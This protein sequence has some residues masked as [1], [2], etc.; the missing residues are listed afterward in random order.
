MITLCV[1]VVLK[2]YFSMKFFSRK[3]TKRDQILF[4]FLCKILIL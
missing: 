3:L 2:I 1:I 4:K